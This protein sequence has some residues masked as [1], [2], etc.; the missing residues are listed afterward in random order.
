MLLQQALVVR[1]RQL[2]PRFPEHPPLQP[3]RARAAVLPAQEAEQAVHRRQHGVH[4]RR[5]VAL[6]QQVRLPP[7]RRLARDRPAAQPAGKRAYVPQIFL[8]RAGAALSAAQAPPV[9]RDK[10]GRHL[11]S[12]TLRPP[13]AV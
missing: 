7:G 5:G 2:P 4:R 11:L 13:S 1:A 12:H 9:G 3:Q 8:H 6:L 10:R